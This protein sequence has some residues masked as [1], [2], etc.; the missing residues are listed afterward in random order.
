MQGPD[1]A[2]LDNSIEQINQRAK[3][4]RKSIEE[5]LHKLDKEQASITWPNVLDNYAL[6]SGQISTLLNAVKS[7]KTP[8]LRNFVIMPHRISPD[9]D[10]Q[11]LWLTEGRVSLMSHAEVPDYLRTKPDPAVEDAERQLTMEVASHGDQSASNNQPALFNKHCN[12]ALEKIKTHGVFQKDVTRQIT[13]GSNTSRHTQ[14]L[15]ATF[16]YGRG[17]KTLPISSTSVGV[18][19]G[20]GSI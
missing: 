9:P 11:L 20:S 2:A 16:Y 6:L 3:D 5:F 1:R 15:F 10:Q 4:I 17:M 19:G 7:D 18:G 14:E 8:P 12:K 13:I